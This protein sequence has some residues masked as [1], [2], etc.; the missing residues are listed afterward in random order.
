MGLLV[1]LMALAGACWAYMICVV[2]SVYMSPPRRGFKAFSIGPTD[3]DVRCRERRG[4]GLLRFTQNP[5][6]V[7]RI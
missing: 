2:V 4:F 1:G 6:Y 7:H 3:C 5:K